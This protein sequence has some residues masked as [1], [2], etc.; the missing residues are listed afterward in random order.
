MMV[1]RP[2][3]G[4]EIR[5][6]VAVSAEDLE[7]TRQFLRTQPGRELAVLF[8]DRLRRRTNGAA[9]EGSGPYL[10]ALD[11]KLRSEY[12]R[13]ARDAVE[14]PDVGAILAA[15]GNSL[16]ALFS[17]AAT[18]VETALRIQRDALRANRGRPEEEQLRV[19]AALDAVPLEGA[20]PEAAE[21][22][23]L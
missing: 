15:E 16:L 13:L 20:A 3:T 12:V 6:V 14:A 21:I 2:A 4:T 22:G 18:A 9:T 5:H 8:V 19:R 1:K 23:G 7:A 17:S 10:A 11:E